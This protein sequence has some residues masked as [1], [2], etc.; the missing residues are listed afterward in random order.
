MCLLRGDNVSPG[1]QEDDDEGYNDIDDDDDDDYN[2]CV[3]TM[4]R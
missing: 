4:R 1:E 2:E 3:S